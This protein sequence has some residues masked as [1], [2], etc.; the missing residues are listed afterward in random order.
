[1]VG[2]ILIVDVC[3]CVSYV[4]H[5]Y[6]QLQNTM[7]LCIRIQ[8]L[9]CMN[10]DLPTKACWSDEEIRS[11]WRRQRQRLPRLKLHPRSIPGDSGKAIT[12]VF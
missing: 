12:G 11:K 5:M 6:A 1:M 3:V 8:Y 4:F 2:Y 10:V 7:S 9:C